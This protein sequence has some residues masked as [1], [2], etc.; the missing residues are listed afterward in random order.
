MYYESQF[1]S[2]HFQCQTCKALVPKSWL[3][4]RHAVK[5]EEGAGF[6][7]QFCYEVSKAT[8]HNGNK[9]SLHQRLILAVTH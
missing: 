1:Q 9:K 3:Q 5:D 7:S 2:G 4:T 8:K 6:C